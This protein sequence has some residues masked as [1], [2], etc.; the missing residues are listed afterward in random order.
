MVCR[1][2]CLL[3]DQSKQQSRDGGGLNFVACN[4]RV[5]NI[6]LRSDDAPRLVRGAP[7][8]R[9]I[10]AFVELVSPSGFAVHSPSAGCPRRLRLWA[11]A[12]LLSR[13]SHLITVGAPLCRQGFLTFRGL[14]FSSSF[15][16]N[17][18][19]FVLRS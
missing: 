10:S 12:H 1:I 19:F 3:A 7:R 4:A 9:L 14:H 2:P 8:V 5:Q 16:E 13:C 15:V 17:E 6:F 18:I 11:N